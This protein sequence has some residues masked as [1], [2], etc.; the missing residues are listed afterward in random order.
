VSLVTPGHIVKV[1][2]ITSAAEAAHAIEAGANALGFN[3]YPRSP[4]YIT[5]QAAHEIAESITARYLRVGVFV[6][7]T[8]EE[9]ME[10]ASTVPLDVLQ[11]HGDKLPLHLASSFRVWQAVQ[12]SALPPLHPDVEAFLLDTP[13]PLYGGSG[14]T[15]DWTLAAAFP[16]RFLLAG[17]LDASNV[18][19]AIRT[20]H[21]WGVDACSRIE[22]APGRKDPE[23]VAAFVHAAEAEFAATQELT[24]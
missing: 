23:R 16:Q 17:G 1:C 3:F 4:R 8:E 21:P 9:L 12:A 5:P 11:L 15:F 7:P 20:A 18:A 22:A 6:N 14:E 2:G 10:A 24:Q 13:T 19:S